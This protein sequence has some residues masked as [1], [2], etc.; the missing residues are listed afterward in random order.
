M[1]TLL[2]AVLLTTVFNAGATSHDFIGCTWYIPSGYTALAD[3]GYR[4]TPAEDEPDTTPASVRFADEGTDDLTA[5]TRL[6]QLPG[7]EVVLISHQSDT[8][9]S[10][11]SLSIKLKNSL[12]DSL[13]S[14]TLLVS[15]KNQTVLMV[16]LP[17]ADSLHLTRGCV[18]PAVVER[19]Y[20]ALAQLEPGVEAFLN[21][22]HGF[23]V[24]VPEPAKR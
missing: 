2:C 22:A 16:S 15:Q 24:L 8:G 1:K 19:H 20:A 18:P 11:K 10:Y 12:G 4:K 9:Y 7:T 3:N 6:A 17:P 21:S 23:N 5:Y 14:S 13:S